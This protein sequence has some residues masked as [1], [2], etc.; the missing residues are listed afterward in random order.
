MLID[1]VY[2]KDEKYY[3]NV[4]LEEYY[5]VKDIEIYCSISE[6]EYSDEECINLFLENLK[7]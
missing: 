1:S 5:F 6:E 4:F 7:T 2:R 3:P